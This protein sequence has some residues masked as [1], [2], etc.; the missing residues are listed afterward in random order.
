MK[1]NKGAQHMNTWIKSNNLFESDD[2]LDAFLQGADG[3]M[4]ACD[5]PNRI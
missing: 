4:V 5:V 3:L 2:A 1:T